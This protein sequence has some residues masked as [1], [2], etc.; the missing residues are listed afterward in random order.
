[1]KLSWIRC[2]FTLQSNSL[3]WV[4]KFCFLHPVLNF[5]QVLQNTEKISK[6]IKFLQDV[7]KIGSSLREAGEA[8]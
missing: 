8:S 6:V 7:K 2:Y 3:L 4:F 5:N 1:M